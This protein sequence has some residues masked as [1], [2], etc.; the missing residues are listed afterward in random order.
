[1]KTYKA[2]NKT[3]RTRSF[4]HYLAASLAAKGECFALF[5][6]FTRQ[7]GAEKN[8]SEAGNAGSH[9]ASL[10][11]AFKP[12]SGFQRILFSVFLCFV[13][14]QG[15][16]FSRFYSPQPPKAAKPA[17]Q[18]GYYYKVRKGDTLW[19]ISRRSQVSVDILGKVNRLRN[20]HRLEV[21]QRLWIPL[22]Y[23]YRV[24][25]GDTLASISRRSGAGIHQLAQVNRLPDPDRLE[26]SQVLWIPKPP[27]APVPKRSPGQVA[28]AGRTQPERISTR[29]TTITREDKSS[30]SQQ[31]LEK[32][33]EPE[34]TRASAAPPKRVARH[35]RQSL[36]WPIKETFKISSRFGAGKGNASK[37]MIL[38][39]AEGTP[40]VAV[41]D[42]T[43][44]YAGLDSDPQDR[45]GKLWGYG[46]YIWL[47]HDNGLITVY[48]H[49]RRNLVETEQRVRQGQIIAEV[50]R[51]GQSLNGRSQLHFEVRDK[52]TAEA[53]NPEKYLP[54]QR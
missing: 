21:G 52:Y 11:G 20:P 17:Y 31:K 18:K 49:N 32:R 36:I 40:V 33:P 4:I 29:Q 2:N 12:K 30:S 22:G 5:Y 26:I 54:P 19:S 35:S 24:R 39:A 34:P 42:G 45:I 38:E 3:S 37:G 41:G 14:M 8:N 25:K 1:L 28:S 7:V 16:W 44:I 27:G 53:Y 6:G 43:V 10:I 23:Y 47:S 13:F 51:T 50:G 48:A 9:S 46:N 15:C